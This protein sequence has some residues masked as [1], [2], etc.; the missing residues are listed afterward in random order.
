MTKPADEVWQKLVDFVESTTS[1]EVNEDSIVF[2]DLSINGLDTYSFMEQFAEEFKVDLSDLDLSKNVL[3]EYELGNIFLTFYRAL[4]RR[5]ALKRR[6]FKVLHL[7]HV[8]EKR[9]WFDPD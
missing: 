6:S 3:S 7:Y 9:H 2:D 1:V 4:F 5:K 8:I